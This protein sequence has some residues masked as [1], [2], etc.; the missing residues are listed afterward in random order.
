ML[1]ECEMRQLPLRQDLMSN[2]LADTGTRWGQEQGS[3]WNGLQL[4]Q[5]QGILAHLTNHFHAVL[6]RDRVPKDSRPPKARTGR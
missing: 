4:E 6:S 3:V 1:V 5:G 2:T